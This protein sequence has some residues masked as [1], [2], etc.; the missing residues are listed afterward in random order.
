MKAVV[1]QFSIPRYALS[2]VLGPVLPSAYYSPLSCVPLADVPE[3]H[4]L[5]A[6]WVKVKTRYG[7]ICGSDIGLVRLHDSPSSSPYSSLPFIFG[8]DGRWLARSQS[9]AM[10]AGF[11]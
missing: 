9:S 8:H 6:G 5:T 7:C 3:P 10:S 11:A 4:L 2:M 1:F